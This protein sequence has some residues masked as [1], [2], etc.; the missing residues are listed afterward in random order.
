MN[1]GWI[2][3]LASAVLLTIVVLLLYLRV[4]RIDETIRRMEQDFQQASQEMTEAAQELRQSNRRAAAAESRAEQADRRRSLA[5]EA[6]VRAEQEAQDATHRSE[7]ERLRAEAAESE[8]RQAREEAEALRRAQEAELNRLQDQLN[9]I[10][11]TR[12]TA[13]GVV[14]NLS[15]DALRFEFDRADLSSESRELLSRI[16]GILLTLPENYGI[17]VYGHTD[18]VGTEAYNLKLSQRRAQAVRDYLVEAGIQPEKITTEGFGKSRPLVEGTSP[19]AR[20]QNR[21]VEIGIINTDIR[22]HEALEE[23]PGNL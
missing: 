6:R 19:S 18:D 21:R 11:E 8:A 7:S 4:D 13:L 9:R 23:K 15:G 10:S 14:M 20:A 5:E 3:G 1:P 12:R 2:L 16:A 17:Y 22:Y